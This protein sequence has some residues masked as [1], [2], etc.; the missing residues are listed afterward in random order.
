MGV[1]TTNFASGQLAVAALPGDATLTLYVG[2]GNVFPQ[3]VAPDYAVM[4]I[5]DIAG[6][7]EIVHLTARAGDVLA[8][9]RAQE[10]T[11]AVNFVIDSRVEVRITTGFLN[12][13]VDGGEF[14]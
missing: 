3:P 6:I 2:E 1:I 5:E 4:V 12:E 13:F 10:G 8:V 9:D 11:V 14:P 7:K